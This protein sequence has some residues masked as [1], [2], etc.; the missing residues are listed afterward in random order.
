MKKIQNGKISADEH[1]FSQKNKNNVK[2]YVK[3]AMLRERI[4]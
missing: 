1:H 4:N 3:M 2:V